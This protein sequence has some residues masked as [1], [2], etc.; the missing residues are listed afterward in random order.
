MKD[1]FLKIINFLIK[2]L[3]VLRLTLFWNSVMGSG[4]LPPCKGA[5]KS[6]WTNCFWERT[7]INRDQNE[8]TK[9]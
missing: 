6:N 2:F 8:A 7:Y 1:V 3:P 4:N 9:A 5:D